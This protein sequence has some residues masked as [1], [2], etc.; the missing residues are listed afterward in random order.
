ML[1]S[2]DDLNDATLTT[3]HVDTDEFIKENLERY[4]DM[5]ATERGGKV[6]TWRMLLK[7]DYNS[8]KWRVKRMGKH[9]RSYKILS[10][11]LKA[12]DN[13]DP[14]LGRPKLVRS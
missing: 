13:E 7:S 6:I 8:F 3:R 4:L 14:P 12:G 10:T 9:T 5:T 11:M 1:K 2:P